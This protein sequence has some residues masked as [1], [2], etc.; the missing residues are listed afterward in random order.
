MRAGEVSNVFLIDTVAV[1]CRAWSL[2][3][4][5][6]VVAWIEASSMALCVHVQ[7]RRQRHAAQKLRNKLTGADSRNADT[8]CVGV[9]VITCCSIRGEWI[10]TCSVIH[11]T[12]AGHVTL[13]QGLADDANT[14]RA[15]DGSCRINVVPDNVTTLL[16]DRERRPGSEQRCR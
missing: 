4:P 14:G 8:S 16:R 11:K 10:G 2:R 15:S 5:I 6:L 1:Y 12:H 13:I 7:G 9:G 3:V